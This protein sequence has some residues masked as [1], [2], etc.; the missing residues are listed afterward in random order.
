MKLPSGHGALHGWNR[1]EASDAIA[2]L[3]DSM[4]V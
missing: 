3:E 2:L 1:L 4:H